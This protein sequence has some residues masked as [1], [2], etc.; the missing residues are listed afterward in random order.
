MSKTYVSIAA[1]LLVALT[2]VTVLRAAEPGQTSTEADLETL[3]TTIQANRK[4]LIEVNLGLSEEEAARFWPLY[5]R[6]QKE[7]AAT[8]ERVGEIIEEYVSNFESLS[9]EKSLQ[10]IRAY[11]DAEAERVKV[12]LAYL[13]RFAEILPGRTVARF[14]QIENKMDAV[15]RYDLAE[16]IPVVENQPGAPPPP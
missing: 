6:Y 8:G 4:A 13:D 1:A 9:N 10:L 16:T 12:R 11:L 14:Y 2:G 3:L 5:D 7:I 15:I